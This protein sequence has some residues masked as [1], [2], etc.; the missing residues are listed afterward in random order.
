MIWLYGIA[1]LCLFVFVYP[2]L[3]YP[4][5]LTLLKGRVS[6]PQSRAAS[7]GPSD[8]RLTLVFAAYNEERSLPQKIANLRAIKAAEP[9]IEIFAYCDLSSDRTLDI[10]REA[11]DILQVIAATER[12]GKATGMVRMIAQATG[13][14]CIFTDANVVIDPA[15]LTNLRAHFADPRVGG[16]AGSLVYTNDNDS[17][18]ALAGGMYWRLEERI[19]L[20]ETACGSIM[21]ADGSIFATRRELYPEV[22]S[23]LLDDMIVSMSVPLAGRQLIFAPDVVAYERNTTTTGDEFRRKRR[24]ACR[25][26]NTHR[27]LWPRIRSSF[28]TVDLY[29]YSAHK[30]LR[31]FGFPFLV[32]GGLAILAALIIAREWMV[33]G[34]LVGLGA[35]CIALGMA[36]IRPFGL[37]LELLIAVFAT[38]RGVLDALNGKTYQT[39]APAKSRD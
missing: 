19:K 11:S 23:H 31:W 4:F 34:V 32:T 30:V 21:G 24:I 14:I 20:R 9:E 29:K 15:S 33:L 38:F 39:W 5:S 26:F 3:I 22:P 1:F 10:L 18:T 8:L 17:A 7:S 28:T 35:L 37:L 36:K 13:D 16:L 12:T 25:A 27:Y 6:Q 2:Y